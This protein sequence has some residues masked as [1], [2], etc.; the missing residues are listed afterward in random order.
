MTGLI[1]EL[2]KICNILLQTQLSKMRA[3]LIETFSNTHLDVLKKLGHV[4][5]LSVIFIQA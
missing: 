4:E 2:T 3:I 1:N 5:I